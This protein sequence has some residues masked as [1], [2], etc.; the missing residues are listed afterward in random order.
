MEL[1]A[2]PIRR[3]FFCGRINPSKRPGPPTEARRAVKDD[4]DFMVR[5][6]GCLSRQKMSLLGQLHRIDAAP[7][8][9]ACAS[10]PMASKLW[11]RSETTRGAKSGH[12]LKFQKD[13]TERA[14]L[15]H[16]VAIRLV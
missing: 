13:V 10:P 4:T 2:A 1:Y 16:S 8:V 3:G 9:A 7:A 11:H 5:S 14:C 15:T 12:M 6:E